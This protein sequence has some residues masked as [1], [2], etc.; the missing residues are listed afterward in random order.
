M[1]TFEYDADFVRNAIMKIGGFF[2]FHRGG[3]KPSEVVANVQVKLI[4]S[5]DTLC[6]AL[7]SGPYQ[8]GKR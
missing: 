4:T 5:R 1:G 3:E 7:D 8:L 6:R 2:Q